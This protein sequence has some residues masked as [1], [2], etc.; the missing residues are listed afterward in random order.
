MKLQSA[1]FEGSNIL[2]E[3]N[4]KKYLDEELVIIKEAENILLKWKAL[5]Y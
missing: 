3:S 5:D 2:V 4:S 1:N